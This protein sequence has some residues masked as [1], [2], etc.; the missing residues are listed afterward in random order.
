MPKGQ[1][2]PRRRRT[3]RADDTPAGAWEPRLRVWIEINARGTLG[4]GKLY[5]LAA[6]GREKS[7]SAAARK[8]RMSYRLAWEHLRQMEQR[9]GF[10]VVETRRG[11]PHGGGMQL[12]TAGQALVDAYEQFRTDVDS[13]AQQAFGRHFDP[14][15]RSP[16]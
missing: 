15:L 3:S 4:P 5:L 10:P 11:G 7:L 16:Q 8:L 2:G 13:Y 1:R 9:A 12:T 14:S 6:I